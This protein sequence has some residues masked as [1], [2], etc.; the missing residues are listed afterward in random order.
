[1]EHVMGDIEGVICA[2]IYSMNGCSHTVII[3][4]TSLPRD[5]L[6]EILIGLFANDFLDIKQDGSVMRFTLTTKGKAAYLK[7]LGS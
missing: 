7:W 1:M 4:A 3:E 2:P 6:L 5:I